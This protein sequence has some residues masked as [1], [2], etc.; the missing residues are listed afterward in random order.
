[1]RKIY[2]ITLSFFL[3]CLSVKGADYSKQEKIIDSML[4]Y[5]I[6]KHRIEN[7]VKKL[8]FFSYADSLTKSHNKYM[9][10]CGCLSHLEIIN[11]DSIFPSKRLGHPELYSV[12]N[13]VAGNFFQTIVVFGVLFDEQNKIEKFDYPAMDGMAQR[14]F[15]EWKLSI[16]HNENMLNR[17]VHKGAVSIKM[18]SNK[19]IVVADF[20]AFE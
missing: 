14:L 19:E 16:M 1:M 17:N 3:L 7:Y 2:L 20:I 10:S 6:N 4:F 8:T 13:V 11:G 9:I 15:E 18:D 5:K 12:E